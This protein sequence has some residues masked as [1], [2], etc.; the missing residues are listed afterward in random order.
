MKISLGTRR[1]RRITRARW[2]GKTVDI[3][4]EEGDG[5]YNLEIHE[6]EIGDLRVIVPKTQPFLLWLEDS[7]IESLTIEDRCP[8][9][10][11][12]VRIAIHR[13]QLSRCGFFEAQFLELSIERANIATIAIDECSASEKVTI[14]DVSIS[15]LFQMRWSKIDSSCEM[16]IQKVLSGRSVLRMADYAA[17]SS[18][19][20][21]L[22]KYTRLKGLAPFLRRLINAEGARSAISF[23]D[24]ARI[25]TFEDQRRKGTLWA[26]FMSESCGIVA[27]TRPNSWTSAVVGFLRLFIYRHFV[28]LM[29]PVSIL[30][31][32]IGAILLV[33]TLMV[34]IEK[35]SASATA[36][37][38]ST[39][40]LI[41][42][43]F[44]GS[45]PSSFLGPGSTIFFVL[46][47]FF[48]ATTLG[49]FIASVVKRSSG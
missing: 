35:H 2:A 46:L 21:R 10:L 13:C 48:G 6:S 17:D 47:S 36:S 33:S 23:F 24:F 25:A 49:V 40:L 37:F 1:V 29:S 3:H 34:A 5:P 9:G 43:M 8:A 27:V 15:G 20:G 12:K 45:A 4:F 30:F 31:S 14:S 41:T 22:H 28:S 16:L 11:A 7:R 44:H 32:V 38:W 39:L 42:A 18:A 26:E 19:S